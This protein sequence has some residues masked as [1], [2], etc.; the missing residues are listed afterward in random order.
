MISG[1]KYER[2]TADEYVSMISDHGFLGDPLLQTQHLIGMSKWE[3][4]ADDFIIGHHQVRSGNLRYTG[5]SRQKE[6]M[7]GHSHASNELYYRKMPNGTWKFAGLK[8]FIRW[9]EHDFQH[10]F[11]GFE[12]PAP[13]ELRS[14]Q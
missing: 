10:V 8:P 12:S 14:Q 4:V 13:K 9:N 11:R 7:R 5:E 1:K 3:K 2:M 6:E